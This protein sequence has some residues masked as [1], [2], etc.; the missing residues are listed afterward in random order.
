MTVCYGLDVICPPEVS[1]LKAWSLVW[2]CP[3][4]RTFKKWGLMKGDW[5]MEHHLQKVQCRSTGTG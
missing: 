4:G 1:V 5:V 3:D 2:W